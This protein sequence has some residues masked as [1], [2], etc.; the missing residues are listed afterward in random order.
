M[1]ALRR[2]LQADELPM[3]SPI[4]ASRVTNI[5]LPTGVSRE[6]AIRT[7]RVRFSENADELGL[8]F[9]HQLQII[10][11]EVKPGCG[12]AAVGSSQLLPPLSLG[13]VAIDEP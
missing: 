4:V 7:G 1:S 11:I 3:L 13:G 6:Q 10:Y 9:L 5:N 12:A 2:A 8:F